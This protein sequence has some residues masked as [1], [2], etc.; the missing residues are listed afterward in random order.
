MI[1]IVEIP[2]TEDQECRSC[3]GIKP[4]HV[5]V[6]IKHDPRAQMGYRFTLCMSCLDALRAAISEIIPF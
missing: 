5:R 1:E 4:A 6:T 2:K 3:P